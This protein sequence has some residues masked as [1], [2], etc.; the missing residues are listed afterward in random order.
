MSERLAH[1]PA[2][3]LLRPL[4]MPVPYVAPSPGHCPDGIAL[5]IEL[6]AVPV[7][8][9]LAS[10]ACARNIA[11]PTMTIKAKTRVP[12]IATVASNPVANQAIT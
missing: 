4:I 8:L 9:A 6:A 10:A 11:D 12:T 3:L 5:R 2:A 7:A 1:A